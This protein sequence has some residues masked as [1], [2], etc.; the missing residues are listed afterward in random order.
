MALIE[1]QNVGKIYH[2]GKVETQALREASFTINAGE[3][4]SI[5]GPSGSGK[6]TLLHVLGFLD[7]N[8][9]G[10]YR[11]DGKTI[12]DY[13]SNELA[14]VRNKRM[15]FVFQSFNLL[16]KAT[17]I[18][19]VKLPLL[20]SDVHEK[21]WDEMARHAVDS[22]GLSHRI[23]YHSS[24]LSGGEK[25]RVAIARALVNNPAVVFADEPTGNLDSKSGAQVM[26][27]I[28]NLH[29]QGKT[30]IL[31]THETYTAEYA[32]RII[33]LADGRIEN[34]RKV[35]EDTKSINRHFVK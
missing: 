8:T 28:E 2:T 9:E 17:V 3:F 12:D 22:V 31:I 32:Q 34:D 11:F 35:R 5:M 33:T 21:L 19:N 7:R 10:M 13:S 29:H 25:Q 18:E 6:S 26:G 27:I 1:A 24:D 4:V 30:I 14:R 23:G 16:A 15:G 20:Y